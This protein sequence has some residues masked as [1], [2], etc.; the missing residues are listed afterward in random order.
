MR[1]QNS[2]GDLSNHNKQWMLTSSARV[3][4]PIETP[5]KFAFDDSSPNPE[6]PGCPACVQKLFF[7]IFTVLYQH[8]VHIKAYA[9]A[10]LSGPPKRRQNFEFC[11]LLDI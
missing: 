2:I 5:F 4:R 7:S 11:Q 8:D 6:K 1:K 3:V 9:T 10:K